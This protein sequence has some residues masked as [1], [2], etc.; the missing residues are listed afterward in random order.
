MNV[1]INSGI[2]GLYKLGKKDI[3]GNIICETDWISNLITNYGMNSLFQD[4]KP[5]GFCAVG[6]G[7][8]AP[9]FTDTSLVSQL[10]SRVST[11][12]GTLINNSGAPNYF[13]RNSRTFE[14]PVSAIIGNVAEVGLFGAATGNVAFSR[15]LVKDSGGTPITFPVL[16]G[17]QLY[18][19]Y[20]LREYRI[21]S[22]S[23]GTLTIN[24]ID[25]DYLIRSCN[26]GGNSAVINSD[27]AMP[28]SALAIYAIESNTLQPNTSG[29]STSSSS[30]P[31]SIVTQ[32]YIADSFT[33]TADYTWSP[34]AANFGSGIGAFGV[35]AQT[36]DSTLKFA[37]YFTDI[38]IPKTNIQTLSIRLRWNLTR[39]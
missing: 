33:R 9:S 14:F 20:E 21:Q 23:T 10:G 19:V 34:S 24:G 12:L 17:E 2:K 15:S 4:A 26:I 39:L 18:V 31:T 3:K 11:N 30:L 7:N 8:T 28:S 32:T 37:I 35:R 6:S 13:V 38:K 27:S 36:V 5:Y 22:D 1:T 29:P 25:Y 16:S